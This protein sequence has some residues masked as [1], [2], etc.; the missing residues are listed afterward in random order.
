MEVFLSGVG[1]TSFGK[2]EE[3]L[4]ELMGEAVRA[5]LEDGNVSAV[6]AIYVGV[7][8]P[9]AF[10]H[11]GNF[12][13]LLADFLGMAG[14][15]SVR[16]ETASSTG[17]AAFLEAHNAVAADQYSRV[18]VVAGEKMS[19]LST[20]ETTGILS[21]VIDR[22][23]RRHGATMPALAALVAHRYIHEYQ[24]PLSTF[25]K[26]M[27]TIAIKNH[28]NGLLNPHAH[29]RKA[30]NEQQYR[31]S[32]M[33]S[34]PLRLFDCAPISDGAAAVLLTSERGDIRIAGI[35]HGTD[36]Y[37]IRNR[38]SLTSFASTRIAAQKAYRMAHLSPRDIE[39]AEI[40]DAFT[41]LELIGMVDLGFFT[42]AEARKAVLKG[43]TGLHGEF[44]VNP[45]GG[46]KSR[47]HPVGGSGLAQ[48]V[49][50]AFQL[51]GAVEEER[52]VKASNIGLAHSVGGLAT[53]TFVTI[54]ERS[55]NKRNLMLEWSSPYRA[56]EEPQLAAPPLEVDLH[57]NTG[58]LE[59]YTVLHTPP[60]GF[61]SP[62]VLGLLRDPSGKRVFARG[63]GQDG[64][65]INRHVYLKR[66]GE[67]TYF[68]HRSA[69]HK[70]KVIC[71]KN[72]R[73]YNRR[74]SSVVQSLVKKA[75]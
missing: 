20:A 32:R 44:P 57:S 9:T 62:L 67:I 61:P 53:N 36:T 64:L 5:A 37:A 51:R 40:H 75:S 33:V 18:L 70:A 66:M 15:P 1:M 12:A 71:R 49:E 56:R 23:E 59:S 19:H 16:I 43:T 72:Y 21:E 48:I 6:D 14:K 30:I 47:G 42:P 28:G 45:S 29:L 54:L 11:E 35:G 55:D 22:E 50:V 10:L 73:K 38:R 34:T 65:K 24:L 17:A 4:Q 2:K 41:L 58:I 68:T 60:E 31:D 25:E 3:S 69:W 7:M 27:A 46:L 39:F 26:L 13:S 8:S 52:R 63:I 74:V